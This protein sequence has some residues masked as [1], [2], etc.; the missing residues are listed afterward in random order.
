VGFVRALVETW[1]HSMFKPGAFWS[2]VRPD[3]DWQDAVFYAWAIATIT[4][5]LRVPLQGL[6]REQAR[7]LIDM[8]DAMRNLP[9]ETQ[10]L[11][12]RMITGGTGMTL[13]FGLVMQII[14]YPIALLIAAAIIHLFC[15]LFGCAGNGFTATLRATAYAQSPFILLFVAHIPC[16]GVPFFLIAPVYIAVLTI[17]GIMGLQRTTPGR[18]TAAVF[19]PVVVICCCCSGSLF[20]FAGMIGGLLRSGG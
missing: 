4:Y 3:R 14:L 8:L 20:A 13:V 6:E 15:L 17:L 18:A 12:E 19:A 11:V 9:P 16:V 5:V 10:A 2:S 7:R 1:R